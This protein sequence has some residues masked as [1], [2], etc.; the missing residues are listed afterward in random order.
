M[1]EDPVIIKDGDVLMEKEK[2]EIVEYMKD[3]L[4]PLFQDECA[5][6]LLFLQAFTHDSNLAKI[7]Y[8]QWI[9]SIQVLYIQ[10]V[11][12]M[13]DPGLETHEFLYLHSRLYDFL[14][15]LP[16]KERDML[17]KMHPPRPKKFRRRETN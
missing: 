8:K 15:T 14:E 3:A 17:L 9:Y 2:L 4:K 1:Q 7:E 5:K 12:W 6:R 16:N 10:I 13:N 11:K